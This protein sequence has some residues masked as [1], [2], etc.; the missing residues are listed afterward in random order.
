MGTL[1]DALP[2]EAR[3]YLVCEMDTQGVRHKYL[4]HTLD[5]Q[6][7]AKEVKLMPHEIP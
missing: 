3:A 1:W 4:G 6:E 2:K 5:A 7:G